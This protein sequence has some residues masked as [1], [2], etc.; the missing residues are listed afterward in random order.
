MPV[1]LSP[2]KKAELLRLIRTGDRNALEVSLMAVALER[3]TTRARIL[4]YLRDEQGRNVLHHAAHHGER[5]VKILEDIL[6]PIFGVCAAARPWRKQALLVQV[7]SN[8]EDAVLYAIRHAPRDRYSHCLE[9]ILT[10]GGELNDQLNSRGLTAM[11]IAAEA[12]NAGVIRYLA[13]H[14]KVSVDTQINPGESRGFGDQ[15]VHTAARLGNL[16][17]IKELVALKG[18]EILL[19]S[20]NAKRRTGLVLAFAYNR[21]ELMEFIMTIVPRHQYVNSTDFAGYLRQ[22]IHKQ[23]EKQS[24]PKLPRVQRYLPG[25]K[26]RFEVKY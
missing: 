23:T 17:A 16:D 7:D 22:K 12:N 5:G 15:P 1:D 9:T 21:E 6:D 18:V 25:S 20:M 13:L 4:V 14:H 19:K 8:G 2:E 24:K 10:L 26:L 11:H 3:K